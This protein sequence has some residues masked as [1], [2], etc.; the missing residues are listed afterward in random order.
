MNYVLAPT[1]RD[2]LHYGVSHLES[3]T[4]R[5]SGR[6]AWGSGDKGR[7]K[8]GVT[9][10]KVKTL[11]SAS[12]NKS[13]T[14]TQIITWK[15]NISKSKGISRKSPFSTVNNAHIVNRIAQGGTNCALCTY[16]M[17]LR[18]RG[19]DVS[20]NTKTK[21]RALNGGGVTTNEGIA[22]WYTD[23]N[24]N[25]VAFKEFSSLHTKNGV[26]YPDS[27][28]TGTELERRNANIKSEL[29]RQG[30]GTYGHLSMHNM[31][32]DKTNE[33]YGWTLG[34]HDV[35]YKI[36]N[37]QVIIYDGQ[38]EQI[39]PYDEYMVQNTPNGITMYPKSYLRTDNL[40][41]SKDPSTE[42]LVSEANTPNANYSP[43]YKTVTKIK[44][45]TQYSPPYVSDNKEIK[46][47]TPPYS[48]YKS[49]VHIA[50]TKIKE[51]ENAQV[52]ASNSVSSFVD[53]VIDKFSNIKINLQN[54][55]SSFDFVKRLKGGLK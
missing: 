38:T 49:T 53:K 11:N 1:N 45:T 20:A 24:G 16:A 3:K 36:E 31:I 26:A 29:I 48:T 39:M 21:W 27:L 37:G 32:T 9:T 33:H 8:S 10:Q 5:G 44:A 35:F 25:P 4:G 41:L 54:Q 51:A 28:K 6:Y 7:N 22:K 43:S 15:Q 18:E 46:Q 47:Y 42:N 34:G 19:V 14:D 12:K 2:I 40:D 23:K 55:T 50:E 13:G 30:N 17:D 52:K